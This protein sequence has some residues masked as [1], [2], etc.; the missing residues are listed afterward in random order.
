[1]NDLTDLDS[2]VGIWI[3]ADSPCTLNVQGA[4]PFS[5]NIT[6]KTGWN[7]AGYP[8]QTPRTADTTLPQEADI[9]SIYNATAPYLV[10][11]RT[12]LSSVTMQ[13]GE[14]YWVHVTTDVM[15]TVNW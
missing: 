11:D 5:T 8:S 12:D 2:T 10:E 13:E 7:L 15:W 4:E 9:I 14:G 1:M 6:L 3:N